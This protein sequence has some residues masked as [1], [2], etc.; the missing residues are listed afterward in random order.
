VSLYYLNNTQKNK[1]F[2]LLLLSTTKKKKNTN[3]NNVAFIKLIFAL[4]IVNVVVL[5]VEFVVVVL[6]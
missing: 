6:C 2:L 3:Y 5:G 1:L 4:F